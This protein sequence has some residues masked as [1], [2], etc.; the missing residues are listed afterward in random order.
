M[1]SG[2]TGTGGEAET[3][4]CGHH[5]NSNAMQVGWSSSGDPSGMKPIFGDAHRTELW[6]PNLLLLGSQQGF[7][8]D[9]SKGGGGGPSGTPHLPGNSAYYQCF[10]SWNTPLEK[11]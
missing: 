8:Q 1:C 9:F 10:D 4:G 2:E 6:F 5:G 3:P 7:I 11:F